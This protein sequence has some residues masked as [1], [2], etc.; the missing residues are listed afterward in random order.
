MSPTRPAR[1]DGALPAPPRHEVLDLALRQCARQISL[2]W[3]EFC[4]YAQEFVREGYYVRYDCQ[5]PEAYFE[6]RHGVRYR[7]VRRWLSVIEGLDRLPEGERAAA[8]E[9]LVGLGSHKA[10]VLAPVLGRDG[11]DWRTWA[12][13]AASVPEA[14]LQE[15][16]STACGLRPR[17]AP[18]DPDERWW[19]ALLARIPVERQAEV[20]RAFLLAERVA[21]TRSP[22]TAF[23]AIIAEYIST[24]EPGVGRTLPEPIL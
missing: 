2:R 23:L 15:E 17:G 13:R 19:R 6:T 9:T 14:R 16:V 22:V 3:L 18:D 1:A 5:T 12:N 20:Q 24:H 7:T 11:Q 21:E 4:G 8:R 10:G